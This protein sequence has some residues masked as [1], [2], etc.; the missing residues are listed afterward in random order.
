MVTAAEI[1][2]DRGD[3]ARLCKRHP[4]FGNLV[5][6]RVQRQRRVIQVR[7]RAGDVG[8]CHHHVQ[9]EFKVPTSQF[10]SKPVGCLDALLHGNIEALDPPA[11]PIEVVAKDKLAIGT[12]AHS[13]VRVMF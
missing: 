6:Q 1:D 12:H 8:L 9:Q 7:W 11:A 3:L 13:L 5:D 2:P 4:P 10:F